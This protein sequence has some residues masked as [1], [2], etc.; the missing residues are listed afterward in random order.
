MAG[1][2]MSNSPKPTSFYSAWLH[3]TAVDTAASVA[4]SFVR[5]HLQHL[6]LLTLVEEGALVVSELVAN[7]VQATG[8]VGSSVKLHDVRKEH[9]I[10]VQVRAVGAQLYIEVWD[11]S[12]TPPVQ[13]KPDDNAEHGRG[14]LLIEMLS[15]GWGFTH[16]PAGGKIV[17]AAFELARPPQQSGKQMPLPQRAPSATAP[18]RGPVYD[19][20][21]AALLERIL[22]GLRAW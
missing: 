9:V 17:W 5:Q 3:L 21:S 22:Q 13:Q 11:R 18:P 20:A 12:T 14:L 6:G 4:R 19:Q 16:P 1:G 10:A 8:L 7:A 15:Q 2:V